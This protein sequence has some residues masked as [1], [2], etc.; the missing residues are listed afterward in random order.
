MFTN[1]AEAQKRVEEEAIKLKKPSHV[2]AKHVGGVM[3]QT[4][5]ERYA[6][7]DSLRRRGVIKQK[8]KKAPAQIQ[9]PQKE[10]V[11]STP[12]SGMSVASPWT[13][14]D[15]KEVCS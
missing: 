10:T 4:H 14:R 8:K 1:L 15:A 3:V 12:G 11:K 5:P 2:T 6:L 9:I 7:P 13:L